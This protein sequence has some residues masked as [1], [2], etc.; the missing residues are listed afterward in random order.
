L[1]KGAGERYK[2]KKLLIIISIV[3]LINSCV[4]K[5]DA[6]TSPAIIPTNTPTDIPT[7]SGLPAD[8]T[9]QITKT[10]ITVDTCIAG[11]SAT[12]SVA[13]DNDGNIWV[14][15]MTGCGLLAKYDSLGNSIYSRTA[16]PIS[17]LTSD[18][19][20]NWIWQ[21]PENSYS[22]VAYMRAYHTDY[23][24]PDSVTYVQ[25]NF[26]ISKEAN[27]A[28]YSLGYDGQNLY[29]LKNVFTDS[30]WYV[31]KYST[32]G[33]ELSSFQVD[34]P[35]EG[36][37]YWGISY[38]DGYIW[39]SSRNSPGDKYYLYKMTTAGT[40]INVFS[41]DD[42]CLGIQWVASNTFW[43]AAGDEICRINF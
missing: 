4:T 23:L 34:A 32:L 31:Y 9:A 11:G 42:K 37:Q 8:I 13:E 20:N 19:A 6:T 36:G 7:Y 40:L 27:S 18:K 1:D 22:T 33:T 29:T 35:I 28:F 15:E 14:T 26:S 16:D 39:L 38:G 24:G 17:G 41:F 3:I 2:M 25:A 30:S 21:L 43:F 12:A 5:R 10:C